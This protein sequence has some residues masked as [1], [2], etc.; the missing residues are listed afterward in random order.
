MSDSKE[1]PPNAALTDDELNEIAN[2]VPK[3]SAALPDEDMEVTED[4]VEPV[5]TAAPDSS[6]VTKTP[7][8]QSHQLETEELR[9]SVAAVRSNDYFDDDEEF[10]R[11]D[12]KP[13]HNDA[14]I[15][16]FKQIDGVISWEI[17]NFYKENGKPRSKYALKTDPPLIKISSSEG[18]TAEFLVTQNFAKS[19]GSMLNNVN[20]AYYGVSPEKEQ[21]AFSQEGIKDKFSSLK[22]WVRFHKVKSTVAV[23]F[24]GFILGSVFL[25]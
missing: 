8:D 4:V 19:M 2:S 5:S 15:A 18:D 17:I 24:F 25:L 3:M 20:R 23:V 22:Q 14:D 13:V 16:L 7:D 9:S 11:G 21:K 12:D 1:T 6:T 10:L